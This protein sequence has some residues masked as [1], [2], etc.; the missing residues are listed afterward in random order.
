M[1]CSACGKEVQTGILL[2]TSC[3]KSVHSG[4]L[5]LTGKKGVFVRSDETLL[6]EFAQVSV[7][8]KTHLGHFESSESRVA[9]DKIQTVLLTDKRLI[10]LDKRD[11]LYGGRDWPA[12]FSSW[13]YD[14]S[15]SDILDQEYSKE[16]S[17]YEK[18]TT[19]NLKQGGKMRFLA[20]MYTGQLKINP[21][22]TS[23][24]P[25]VDSPTSPGM[26][27]EV[28]SASVGKKL[29]GRRHVTLELEMVW[30]KSY[31]ERMKSGVSIGGIGNSKLFGRGLAGIAR[32][33][34]KAVSQHKAE[35]Y[36]DEVWLDQI[37]HVITSKLNA[38][39]RS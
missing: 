31:L 29:I 1:F 35:L 22:P 32:M 23:D 9:E 15:L 4:P 37:C 13:V 18:E 39:P 7:V 16:L 36:L 6:A 8:R 30:A 38:S 10:F 19:D 33:G 21:K 12:Y 34:V 11:N 20:K 5:A 25:M 3:G 27:I 28:K 26:W 14:L 24:T 17:I 2:C